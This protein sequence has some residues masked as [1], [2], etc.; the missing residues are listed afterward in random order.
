MAI[1]AFL[2][3]IPLVAIAVN[4]FYTGEPTD[5]AFAAE[6]AQVAA[7]KAAAAQEAR[8]EATRQA[9]AAEKKVFTV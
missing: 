9:A 1:V 7:E 3:L 8:A 2:T 4:V 6:A 5:P